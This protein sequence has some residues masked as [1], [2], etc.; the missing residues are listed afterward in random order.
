[1]KWYLLLQEK[2]KNDDNVINIS[3]LID[4]KKLIGFISLFKH[5]TDEVKDLTPWYAT[6]YVKKEYREKGYLK[7]LNDEIIKG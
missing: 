3:G 4:N 2:I 1:M 5:D 7:L 6:M